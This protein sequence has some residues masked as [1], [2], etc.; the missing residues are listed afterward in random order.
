MS[1]SGGRGFFRCTGSEGFS[2]GR[3][4]TEHFSPPGRGFSVPHAPTL[5]VHGPLDAPSMMRFPFRLLLLAVLLTAIATPLAAQ[6]GC[7]TL[8]SSVGITDAG[9]PG[10]TVEVSFGTKLCGSATL[11]AL[12]GGGSQPCPTG[13]CLRIKFG[14]DWIPHGTLSVRFPLTARASFVPSVGGGATLGSASLLSNID[15]RAARKASREPD[16]E[17]E[18]TAESR[19]AATL[20]YGLALDYRLTRRVSVFGQYRGF[21]IFT[22]ERE[23]SG[24]DGPLVIDVGTENRS[25][26]S[27]GLGYRF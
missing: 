27:A 8:S 23:F 19:T 11:A 16:A 4:A 10:A 14:L 6:N 9:H 20:V 12:G 26:F 15:V 7:T 1:V 22:G 2:I 18:F 24:P 5:P 3:I 17:V 13:E 21:S 25:L